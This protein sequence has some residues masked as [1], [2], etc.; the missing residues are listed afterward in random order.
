[1]RAIERE[2]V[3]RREIRIAED[4]RELGHARGECAAIRKKEKQMI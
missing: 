4:G 3:N 2:A 1:M